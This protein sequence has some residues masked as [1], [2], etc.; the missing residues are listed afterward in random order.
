MFSEAKRNATDILFLRSFSK[1]KSD[2][3]DLH[4]LGPAWGDDE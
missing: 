2:T 3:S 1:M 4:K